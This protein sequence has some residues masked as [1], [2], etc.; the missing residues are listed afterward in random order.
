MLCHMTL[1]VYVQKTKKNRKMPTKASAM[2]FLMKKNEKNKMDE[3]WRE[4]FN[5]KEQPLKKSRSDGH[6]SSVHW[7]TKQKKR[8]REEDGEAEW[9]KS[10][11]NFT[12]HQN[13]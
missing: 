13:T 7:K 11:L 6:E 3:P 1:A 9:K 2:I 4:N 5:D 12:Y 10:N 8:R